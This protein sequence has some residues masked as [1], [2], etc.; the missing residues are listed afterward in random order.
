MP[1]FSAKTSFYENRIPLF[2][3]LGIGIGAIMPLSD[4]AFDVLE[5]MPRWVAGGFVFTTQG[6]EKPF[7]NVG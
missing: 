4:L 1:G 7:G 6:G 2:P 3:A 5:A